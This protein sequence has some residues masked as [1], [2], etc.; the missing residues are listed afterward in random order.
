MSEP[1]ELFE[2]AP[3]V[4]L[5][6]RAGLV[7]PHRPNVGRRALLIVLI[8]WLPLVVLV[9]LQSVW[10]RSDEFTSL[11]REVGVHARYLVAAPLLIIAEGVCAPQ[12]NVIAR[13][14][15]SGTIVDHPS[16]SILHAAVASARRM[17]NS[18]AAEVSA[19]ALAYLVSVGTALSYS[20][21]QLPTWAQ[22]TGG[23]PL[24]SLAGWWHTLVSLPLLLVLIFGWLWRLFVWTWLLSRVSRLKLHLV[25][26]HPDRCA[27]LAFL[28]HSVRAFAVVG[29][30]FAVIVAGRS[31]HIVMEG[32][33]LPTPYLVFNVGLL[34]AITALFVGPLLVFVPPLLKAWRRGTFEYG[35]LAEEIG[36]VFEQKWINRQKAGAGSFEKPDFSA[37]ADLYAVT[38]NVHAMR[39]IPVD[40]KDLIAL[41]CAMLLPFVPVV[42][43]AFPMDVIWKN[44][45]S[46]LL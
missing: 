1:D 5:Q 45:K 28:G 7:G 42:L 8:G 16:V 10:T 17:L 14:F 18:A 29:M 27:G 38:A 21:D 32:G 31:A 35:A 26:S 37:V 24:F 11:L 39:L 23:M 15:M 22:P 2:R 25:A 6:R 40:I 44:I 43:L 46:L 36:H 33:G 13:N 9:V 30:A 3:P 4:G 19:I 41:G 34:I 12:L 20:P